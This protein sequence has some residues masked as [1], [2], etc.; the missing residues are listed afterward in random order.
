[1]YT[2]Q[3]VIITDD[4]ELFA[5]A[6]DIPEAKAICPKAALPQADAL[7]LDIECA[8]LDKGALAGRRDVPAFAVISSS[9]AAQLPHISSLGFVHTFMRPVAAAFIVERVKSLLHQ[10]SPNAQSAKLAADTMLHGIGIDPSLSAYRILSRA[11]VLR[12]TLGLDTGEIYLRLCRE[13]NQS[14]R[15]IER[16]M[17]YAIERAFTCGDIALQHRIF[18]YTIDENSGKPTNL[19]FICALAE[20]VK[21]AALRNQRAHNAALLRTAAR[22]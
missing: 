7:V 22:V 13:F 15:N 8:G 2:P 9:S 18:G 3:I 6:N 20:S 17:R 5:Q 11:I 19:E 16:N 4:P 14:Y 10:A 12:V 21:S 1:M